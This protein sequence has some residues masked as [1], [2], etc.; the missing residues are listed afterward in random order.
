MPSFA[1]AQPYLFQNIARAIVFTALSFLL[2]FKASAQEAFEYW[3]DADY[4]PAIPTIEEVLGHEPGDRI[5]WHSDAIRYFEALAAAAP[6]RM[7]ITEYARSWEGREL[8]YAVLS[9]PENM[10]RIDEIQSGMQ[11]LADPRTIDEDQAEE[12]IAS[13]PAVTWLSYGVHGNEISSTDAAML[14]AYHLLASR[15]DERVDDIMSNS[16][17]VIDPMQN[18]DGR[19]RFI[20]GFEIAEGL[21]PDSDRLSAEHDE[22]WPGG[23]TNHYLFDLNRDWF[24]QTQPETQG[25]AA[26]LLEWY[27]VAFVDA[28]EMGSDGTYFFA[29]EAI[30]FNPHLA[31]D[32]RNSLQL[33]GRNNA[34]WFDEFGID[35]FTREVYDAFYPGYGASWPSYFGSVAMTYEQAST[36][37]L[38]FRQYDG[39]EVHYRDTVRNHFV[40]SLATAETVAVNR[41]QLLQDFYDYQVSAIEEGESEDVRAFL[42]PTQADQT[43][44]D[45]MAGLLSRQGVDVLRTTESFSACGVDY[46]TGSYVIRT[47]QPAKRFIRTLLDDEVPMEED[48]LV[49]QEQRRA[50]NLPDQIYDVTG[51]SLPLMFNIETNTCNRAP[52]VDGEL[53]GTDLFV[54]GAVVGGEATVA[55]IVPWG[56]AAAARFMT[57]AMREGLTLKSNDLTFTNLGNEYPAGT[58]IL[59]VADNPANLFATVTRLA[60]ETGADVVAVNDSWVTDGPSFG[61]ANVVRMNPP[62]VAM[63]WDEP[64]AAYSAGN[65]RFVIERQFN[66]PVTVIRTDR[67]RSADLSRYQVL[68]LPLMSGG[69]YKGVLGEAGIENLKGWVNRG[70]VVISLGNATR[71]L[72]DPDVDLLSIRR[73]QAVIELEEV[74]EVEQD[75]ATVDGQYLTSIDE[76]E[77]QTIALEDDPYPVAGVLVRADVHPEHW[78]SAG[79]APTLNVLVRGADVYTPVRIDEGIN[80]ARFQGPDDLVASGYLWEENRRQ[81]A[82]KPFVVS[83]EQ[84]AGQVIAFTQDP[85]VRAYLDGLNVILINA[86]FRGAA[87]ARPV[88]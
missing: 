52:N 32:Q 85:T 8:V 1:F 16:V 63:L 87:H 61:S 82:F 70:G 50:D 29:P 42:V 28:H 36:R 35:Y 11:A 30:P 4:D 34:R 18:P 74:P 79:V 55:Y 25:R 51:W 27:P 49:E 48:F 47:D 67:L 73:E 17:V 9:S 15:G 56:T 3:P 37:G 80:V 75:S 14:T 33:F 58:L 72:A 44:A 86:I 7:S 69:G 59:D 39:V 20:H 2:V 41:A 23:R 45:K 81:L 24:I 78:L 68:I 5:T 88:R 19:D 62:R 83:E 84:G 53:V 13:Q 40:T 60:A 57:T 76:Y 66:Y 26:A 22:P 46:D 71:F 31:E 38:V 12:I 43:A 10:T 54:P 77:A 65:T 64:T 6:E 21:V